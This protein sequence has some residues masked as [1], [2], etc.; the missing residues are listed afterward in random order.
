[1]FK[2]II[3]FLALFSSTQTYSQNSE[4]E[5]G[6]LNIASGAVVGGISALINKEP[7]QKIHRVLG[8]G[9]VQGALGGYLVFE[10]KRLLGTF[11]RKENYAYIWPSKL[12]NSAGTSII[13]N[14]AANRDFWNRWHLNLGFTRL[15]VYTKDQLQLKYR[16]MPFSLFRAIQLQIMEGG[17]DLNQS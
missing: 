8:K 7:N 9:V 17:I 12:I 2:V 11:A 15:D 1:M 16:I 10:S 3:I 4:L 14:A 13:E 6:L 5:F